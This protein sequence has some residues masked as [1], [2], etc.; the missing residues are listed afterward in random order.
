[1]PTQDVSPVILPPTINGLGAAAPI[2]EV[3]TASFTVTKAD[4]GKIFL[5]VGAT[6]AVVV[7]LP[8]IADGPFRCEIING[9]DVDL[10]VQSAVADTI[11]TFNDVAADS[12]AFST[13]SEKIGGAV[14]VLCNGTT[15]FVLARIASSY[16]NVT[17]AT[18]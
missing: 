12:V 3:K 6:A 4:S 18:A 14:D 15:L 8:P 13:S 1:M 16:Q 10:T 17:I 2:I 11:T 5:I 7:T 9:S